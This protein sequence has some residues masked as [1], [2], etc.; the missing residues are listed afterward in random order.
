MKLK[1]ITIS[2]FRGFKKEQTIELQ[3]NLIL[4]KGA[5]GSGKSSFVEA[6]EWLFYD[7][8]SR[9]KKSLCKSEYSG[10]FLRNLH[11]DKEQETFVEALIES[12][13]KYIRLKKK[14]VSPQKKEHYVD[15]SLVEDFSSLGINL[16][17]VHKPILSQVE[18]KHYVETDPK[19]RFEETNKILGIGILSEFR[20]D[21]QDLQKDKKN[22]GEYESSKKICDG[23]ESDLNDLDLK[24]LWLK[25]QRRPFSAK[26]FEDQLIRTIA[27][28]FS[29]KTKTISE[30]SQTLDA[31]FTKLGKKIDGSECMQAL[32]VPD[33]SLIL[34]PAKI[35][36][37]IKQLSAML[38][39]FKP[40][41][42][43]LYTFLETG[44]RLLGD[45][46]CPFCLEK[47]VTPEKKKEIDERISSTK[48]A[49]LLLSK[50]KQKIKA[51]Q[52][53]KENFYQQYSNSISLSAIETV[54]ARIANNP[55]YLDEIKNTDSIKK[56]IF[57]LNAKVSS[58]TTKLD[59]LLDEA[60]SM[61]EGKSEFEEKKYEVAISDA[62]KFA[63][64]TQN[65]LEELRGD[66]QSLLTSLISKAP[67]LSAQEKVS[68]R[69]VVLFQ[70]IIENLEAIKYVGIYEN[71]LLIISGLIEEIGKFE[72]TKSDKLLTKLNLTI[73][74]FYEKLNPKEKTQFSEIVTKGKSRKIQIKAVSH[75]KDMNPVSCFSEAHMNCLCLSVYFSQRVLN[76]SYWDYVVLDDPIQSMDEDHSKN[77]IR[78]LDDVHENKQVIITSHNARFCQDFR[79]LFY[80][81][82]H[83]FYEF[84]GNSV[85][86]PIIDLKE[87]P[88][89]MYMTTAKKHVDGNMEER[90]TSGANLRKAIERLTVEILRQKGKLSYRRAY[91]MKL[92]R[93]LDKIETSQ[94][95][96]LKEIGEIKGTLNIC[97]SACHDAPKREV[98]SNELKDG[99]S[100]IEALFSKYLIIPTH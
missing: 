62:K 17:E 16:A 92:D 89:E 99:I 23:L 40:A 71:N 60:K 66:L 47:T 57:S 100:I 48:A 85:E 96:T 42:A 52:Q 56:Q 50:M 34:S 19:D 33:N 81:R 24:P 67:S 13:G 80:G 76:N 65:A 61:S 46:T 20:T 59:A 68:L 49:E 72:K 12:G 69:K 45:T 53:F 9:K 11:A 91:E 64:A 36:E 28:T 79:D 73:K 84:S 29:F 63:E 58:F 75:G 3:N 98:T 4:I 90:A 55:D 22:D 21:L 70:K 74:D 93:R 26:V 94:L 78:I 37:E 7:E 43:E 97:D 8:I 54:R 30:L 77:L 2:A 27:K 95:L 5:N 18:V 86:G 83:A 1:A 35:I 87:A 82:D 25:I 6:I 38:K 41:S 31:E 51:T 15:G 44:K 39:Q 32:I 88:F 14:L 10:E